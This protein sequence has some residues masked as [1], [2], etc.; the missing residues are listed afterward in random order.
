[1]LVK[2]LLFKNKENKMANNYAIVRQNKRYS[3]GQVNG[4]WAENIRSIL[5]KN[6]DEHRSHLNIIIT[7]LIFQNYDHFF[8]TRKEQ[9][10]IANKQRVINEKKARIRDM[11][12]IT[13]GKIAPGWDISKYSPARPIIMRI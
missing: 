1:M 2:K 11:P 13:P 6:V 7:P 4:I 12:P 3:P 9:I 5:G 10:R 8:L